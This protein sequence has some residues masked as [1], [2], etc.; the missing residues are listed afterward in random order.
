[1]KFKKIMF[2]LLVLVG[3]VAMAGFGISQQN[4]NV[5]LM[6]AKVPSAI[7]P[8]I[9]VPGSSADENRFD[10]LIQSLDSKNETHSL[11]KVRVNK[12]DSLHYSGRI[13]QSDKRPY[14]VVGFQNNQDGYENIKKQAK[15]F[16]IAY[17]ALSKRYHFNQFSGIGHSNGGLVL[18]IFLEKYMTS[19]NSID[20]LMTI[21]TPFN[22][23]N[24]SSE[25]TT[26]LKDLIADRKKI[27]KTLKMYSVAGT[28]SYAGDGIVPFASV[29]SGKYIYQNQANLYTEMIVTGTDSAHSDLPENKQTI[30][31][32]RRFMLKPGNLNNR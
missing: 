4:A 2:G 20:K 14:I 31:L 3:F 17:T 24:T 25:K 6:R 19:T 21:G 13:R 30:S 11:L 5:K 8:I 18:T 23:E 7:D 16:S 32:I 12:D 10:S 9:L 22:L 27:P 29:D 26:M 15:W 28:Q 1:M